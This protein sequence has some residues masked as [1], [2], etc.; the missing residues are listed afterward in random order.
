MSNF[1][2]DD[3]Q[4]PQESEVPAYLLAADNH[5]L[6]NNRGG[7]W[8]DSTTWEQ[9]FDS[10]GKMIATGVLSGVN[11]FYNTG[12]AIG[13]MFGDN[14]EY[15]DTK[16]LVIS[17]F[18]SNMGEYYDQNRTAADLVGFIA[19]SIIPGVAGVKLLNAGQSALSAAASRGFI[20]SNLSKATGLLVP[21]TEKYIALAAKDISAASATFSAINANGVKALAAG[22]WQNTLEAAAFETAVQ[23]TM[24]KS[25]ILDGQDTSDIIKNIA[26]GGLVGGVIGGAFEAAGTLTAVKKLVSAEELRVK[27]FSSRT[28]T[29]EGTTPA[30]KV[31]LMAEDKETARIPNFAEDNY[32]VKLSAAKDKLTR[33]DNEIR[34]EI[35]KIVPGE[36]SELGNMVADATYGQGSKNAIETFLHTDEIARIGQPTKVEAAINKLAK[37]RQVDPTLQV[38]FVKLTGEGAGQVVDEAPVI[39]NLADKVKISAKNNTKQ[40]VES[41]VRS[42]N[43]KPGQVWN[44]VRLSQV[45]GHFEAEARHIWADTL[46]SEIKEGSAI[47]QWDIPV[48][49]RAY[50]DG[51]TNIKVVNDKGQVLKEF[52]S[53]P[54]ELWKHIVDTKLQVAND[55]IE[56]YS[57]KGNEFVERSTVAI[58]KIVNTKVARLEGTVG[59]DFEDFRAWQT[60]KDSYMKDL[61]A[62]GLKTPANETADPRF[63]PSYAKVTRRAKDLTDL[64]GNVIDAMTFIKQQQKMIEQATNNVVAK[65]A[66]DLYDSI[67]NIPDSTLLKADRY[68]AGAKLLSY[69]NGGYGSLE[70]LT[71]LM[72]SVTK[73]LKERFRSNTSDMLEGTLANMGRKQEAAIEFD[74]INQK[75]TRSAKQ[76]VRYTDEVDGGEYLVTKDALKAHTDADTGALDF[77]SLFAELPEDLIKIHNKETSDFVDAHITLAG[78]RTTTYRELRA[79]QGHQDVKDPDVF[80]PIRQSP[81]DYPFFAFVKDPRVTGQGHTTMISAASESKLQEMIGKVPK[82]YTVYTK[83]DT[84]E[85]FKARNEYE[86]QRTLHENYIDGDLKSRGI[87]SDFFTKTD[88]QK[89]VNDILKQHLRE[90]DTLAVE[91]MR[92][93]N[94]RAFDWLEDQGHAY[95]KVSASKFGSY[96]DRLEKAGTN[97][98]LDYIKT[99][100]DIS[101][102]PEY[103]LLHGFNK[104]LD[105]AVSKAV[106]EVSDLFAKARTTEDL[107][108]INGLLTKYGMGTGY[109]DAATDLLANH[110]APKGE[111]TK[112]VRSANAILS[113][114]TLGLDPLNAVNNAIGANILRST[115]LKQITDAIKSG[116]SELAGKLADL[117]KVDL[118]GGVGK[119]TSPTKLVAKAFNNFLKDDGTLAARYKAAGLIK[120]S[121][122]QF[123]DILD[124]FTLKGTETVGE[125]NSRISKSLKTAQTLAEKGEKYTGNK[126]AEEM[127]R[128]ISADCMRQLTDLAVEKG[129][130]NPAE[131]LSYMNTFVN[132]VEGNV[133]ASQRPVMF[134]GPVGQA[135]GLFQS[136]QFNLMQQMFRYVGEGTGKDAAMLLGLQGTFY[137]LQGLPAFQ[138]I[139]QHIVGTASGNT[140]H[141]D[142]YDSTYGIVGKQMGDLL[143]YGLPS[144]LLQANLYSRGDINPRQVTILPTSIPEIPFVGAFGK[145]LGSVKDTAFK[146]S[147]GG[148]VWESMLQG[149]EHNGLSRPLAGL[150]Q[151]MQAMGEG[152]K[153]YSTTSKGSILFSN[154]FMSWATAVRLAGGRPLDEA[155]VNDGIFRI[156]SYSQYDLN[157]MKDLQETVKTSVIQGNTPSDS[158][159]IKFSEEYVKSG[160]KQLQFNKF[161]VNQFKS[162]NTS[163]SQKI[164]TQLQN[165][166]AQKLQVIMGGGTDDLRSLS[167]QGE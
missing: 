164:V 161:M 123:K 132:R 115:E 148:Q 15:R 74:T 36:D 19:G 57:L 159:I 7:S 158:Q 70:S 121:T 40:A 97:P 87:M 58:A 137:G 126:L 83:R 96:S 56:K 147:Q 149:L 109:R 21:Q 141:V 92:A 143:M 108:K 5:N 34:T 9:K 106:G 89:I 11:S 94:Q 154:D 146:I 100:L 129:L 29:Q 118:P 134:Q 59:K 166:F 17:T 35:H 84:E 102:A 125:L 124:D 120:D 73:Q 86:Y 133:I 117:L 81:N 60:A 8:F 155:I 93:K 157:K 46:L 130:M 98:Y 18:D 80:R 91:L 63:L 23:A 65:A 47:H 20:G 160:G 33:I 79:T 151:T 6:G 67:P 76:W 10:V 113:R 144:N 90:D 69:A 42:F 68:G 3:S 71:Q 138:F 111:L 95:T 66:G 77:D 162:A 52:F 145:F 165:P 163:E 25:P 50:K 28:V 61:S 4:V 12:V 112:F 153:V 142:L 114:L 24:F 38:S 54:S 139:N 64:N 105:N 103:T 127:N 99:A 30:E 156:H 44:P 152:G 16:D 104:F 88:P 13:N 55:L 26:F 48:L 62:K 101:K 136:Y 39:M 150:A 122:T 119:M 72:G 45:T 116:D 49:E 53:S 110:T 32:D 131:Q 85:F 51:I 128:F 31:I 37:E 78:N 1:L 14:S 43:F 140:K 135:I 27:P 82:E 75:A 167:Q 107:D 2:T 41:E 22:F